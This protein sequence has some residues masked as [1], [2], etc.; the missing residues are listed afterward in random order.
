MRRSDLSSWSSHPLLGNDNSVNDAMSSDSLRAPLLLAPSST[1]ARP[2]SPKDTLRWEALPSFY[3]EPSSSSAPS[4][5]SR[6]AP[7]K[8]SVEA[9]LGA[10]AGQVHAG[11]LIWG[12]RAIAM[13]ETNGSSM[14]SKPRK[15]P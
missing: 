12:S 4:S 6:H 5:Q 9:A 3:N 15:T 8:N 14:P 11:E 10:A 13:N 2:N 1:Q 7:E